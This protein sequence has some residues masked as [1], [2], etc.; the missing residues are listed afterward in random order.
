MN[1][2]SKNLVDLLSQY[3]QDTPDKIAYTFLK[4]GG[5]DSDS[6]TYGELEQT[7]IIIA[8]HLQQRSE[9]G[10]RVILCYPSGLEYITAFFGCLY[11]G[12]LAVPLY[13]PH[14]RRIDER[15]QAVYQDAQPTI[16]LTSKKIHTK[17][18]KASNGRL[19][20]E[21]LQW[22]A[23]DHLETGNGN[24]RLAEQWTKPALTAESLAY[25]QYTSG[26]T[27]TPKGVMVSH[28][29]LLYNLRDSY[30]NLKHTPDDVMVSWLPL[31]HDMGLIFC[32]LYPLYVGIHGVFMAPTAFI[33]SPIR[34]LNAI[35]RYKGTHSAAPNFAYDYCLDKIPP[36]ER[37]QL[38]LRSW[39]CAVT[40][41]EPVRA[42][43]IE[44]FVEGFAD[45]NFSHKTFCPG[46][47]L[48]EAT[49]MVTA[50][51]EVEQPKE[52][53]FNQA[54][55]E[56]HRVSADESRAGTNLVACGAPTLETRVAI[57]NPETMHL[58]AADEVGEI[59]VNG[60]T[61]AQGYWQ[62]E[63]ATAETFRAYLN[64]GDDGPF[65]RTGDLGF[66]YKG[67]LF[68]T[69]RLKDLIIIRG[70]NHYPQDIELT[71][72]QCHPALQAD[73]TIA[74]SINFD[75]RQSGQER[76]IRHAEF[77]RLVV[78]LE[79]DR[80]AIR[81]INS[82]QV[83]WDIRKAISE[84]HDIQPY[85]IVLVKPG[86]LPKT[87]SGKSQRRTCGEQYLNRQLTILAEW[88]ADDTILQD[89]DFAGLAHPSLELV[90]ARL[91]QWLSQKLQ[92]PAEVIE[93]TNRLAEYGLD[94]LMTFELRDALYHSTGVE[95]P[96][97]ELFDTMTTEALARKIVARLSHLQPNGQPL[98]MND[99]DTPEPNEKLHK[100]AKIR[101][102]I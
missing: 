55:L 7:A 60:P 10:E 80:S 52:Y 36:A 64:N 18:E 43:T 24:D 38:D 69:G 70:R 37:S 98:V 4:N 62:N 44:R 68:I 13:P 8:T 46:Y 91:C 89:L 15:L 99:S 6:I 39:R 26:S 101:V 100:T 11:A 54:A 32:I 102:R 93:P 66:L 2:E 82:E 74:V 40:G 86:N 3:A 25:L 49:L 75:D 22:I 48:A 42:A 45:A 88:R 94:S 57:V 97:T 96:L 50:T 1:L 14:T 35:T 59:W 81:S 63:E 47:G 56:N 5:N 20:L 83:M 73:R 76:P 72:S 17:I 23:T 33:E 90:E 28:G 84:A 9:P 79:V 61:V 78:V 34:W 87:T 31:F 51:A 27:S 41:A 30:E 85:A 77:E 67:Q 12:V 21:Q 19:E 92:V 16:A 95:L 71:A 65:L 29:N 53:R 58:C